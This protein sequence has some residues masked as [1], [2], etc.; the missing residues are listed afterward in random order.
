MYCFDP[1]V[2]DKDTRNTTPPQL[3]VSIRDMEVDPSSHAFDMHLPMQ[4][5][6]PHCG[7]FRMVVGDYA[8]WGMCY[9]CYETALHDAGYDL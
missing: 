6:C 9:A 7:G 2:S 4:D 8:C 1:L 5:P 3:P